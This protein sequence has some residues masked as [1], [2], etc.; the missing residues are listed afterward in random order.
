MQNRLAIP[1][2]IINRE[3]E[4]LE[5]VEKYPETIP[6]P[7]AAKFLHMDAESLRYNI[8]SGKSPFGG[9]G[10]QKGVGRYRGFSIQTYTFFNWFTCHQGLW[11]VDNDYKEATP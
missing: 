10:W 2:Q 7:E 5:L 1:Q 4:L 11:V 3:R 8:D 9:L 6:L